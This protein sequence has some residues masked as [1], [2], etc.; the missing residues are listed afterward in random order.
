MAEKNYII[1]DKAGLHARPSTKL[2]SAVSGFQSEVLIDYNGKQ[3]N[4]KSIMV[5][6]L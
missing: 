1:V 5:S 2:V 3:V 6:C 4:L